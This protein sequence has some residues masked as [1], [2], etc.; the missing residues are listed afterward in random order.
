MQ[1]FMKKIECPYCKQQL[2]KAPARK[3]KCPHCG[4]QIFVRKRELVTEEEAQVL[5]W[6]SRLE[7]YGLTEQK[8]E[9]IRNEL[10]K[11]FKTKATVNDT[12]WS[13]FNS[14]IN[15]HPISERTKNVYYEMAR[16]VSMEGRDSK[17][18]IEAALKSQLTYFKSQGVKQVWVSNY[19]MRNDD[20]NTCPEC[21]KLHGKR[22]QIDDALTKMPIPRGCTDDSC[23]CEYTD[24]KP[25]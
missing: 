17:P 14:W 20:S 22:F 8:F 11:R 10:S 21:V 2:D 6:V 4:N 19:G 7:D 5:D 25:D 23:R 15:A 12:I 13:F 18:L 16:L 3:T 1:P 9:K 24:Y